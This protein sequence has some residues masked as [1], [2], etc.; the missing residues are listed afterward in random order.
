MWREATGIFLEEGFLFDGLVLRDTSLFFGEVC[1]RNIV[2]LLAP[3]LGAF[4]RGI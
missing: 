2:L 4:Y 1:Y 3:A